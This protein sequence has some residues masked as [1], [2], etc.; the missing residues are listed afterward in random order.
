MG[1][2]SLYALMIVSLLCARAIADDEASNRPV[3]RSFTYG[4]VYAKSIPDENYGQK[5]KTTLYSVGRASDTLICSY[6]WFANEIYIG[7]AGES[8]VVRFGPW[9]RGDKP[10]DDHLAIGIY[11]DG[12]TIKEYSTKQIEALGAGVSESVSH[13]QVFGKRLG[14]RWL[15]GNDYVFEVEGSS[16][17]VFTFDTNTGAV[18]EK[19]AQSPVSSDGPVPAK[20]STS[21]VFASLPP[22]SRFPPQASPHASQVSDKVKAQAVQALADRIKL[23]GSR[24]DQIVAIDVSERAETFCKPYQFFSVGI[25][26]PEKRPMTP[27]VLYFRMASSAEAF[28]V[29]SAKEIAALLSALKREVS[30][31]EAVLNIVHVFAD[32]LI[33]D[34]RTSMPKRKSVINQYQD[35]KPEDWTLAILS[36]DSGWNVSVT[37]VTDMNIEYCKRYKLAISKDG[38]IT[39]VDEKVVYTYTMYK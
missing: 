14:F 29:N 35:Q 4:S 22:Y 21:P 9:Q 20:T 32:I 12:K 37:M 33:A 5:G 1:L 34:I 25:P 19:K 16:G 30:N 8:T 38:Q 28:P 36:T 26:V 13:Y 3:V 15:N 2:K 31:D 18:I 7:G 23:Y 24:V 11:R 27:D 17:K 6:D 39:V 10:Q